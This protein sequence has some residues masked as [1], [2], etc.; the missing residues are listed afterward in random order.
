M[1]TLNESLATL[2]KEEFRGLRM[3][4]DI[5]VNKRIEE[6]LLQN[7]RDLYWLAISRKYKLDENK[8]YDISKDGVVT[9]KIKE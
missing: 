2:T 6:N 5:L 9:E 8:S 3:R 7:E 1:E 4:E